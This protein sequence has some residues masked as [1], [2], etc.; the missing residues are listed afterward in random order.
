MRTLSAKSISFE[1]SGKII[2]DDASIHVPAGSVTGLL[3]PNGSGKTTFFDIICGLK[4]AKKG[5]LSN[6]FSNQLYLSQTVMTPPALRMFDIFKMTTLLCSSSHISQ[7]QALKKL[8]TWSP[9][10]VE[11]YKDIWTKK[12]SV[13]S[14]GEKRWFFTLSLL[15][16]EADLVILD[17]PTA[18]VDPEFRH[19]I[20][21]CLRGAANEGTAILVSSHSIEEVA[22]NCSNF[23]MISQQKFKPFDS[24]K[25]FM[26]RYGSNTLDEA[27]IRAAADHTPGIT[28]PY[29]STT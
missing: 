22:N 11:R 2:F 7:E 13:C 16:V 19:Y 17:E 12:S 21:K 29:T 25:E 4:K 23:Y 15:A 8:S 6:D 10:I 18:G 27:F 28:A 9:E 5:I 3:G 14:Y 24:G 1:Y 26:H 20:W